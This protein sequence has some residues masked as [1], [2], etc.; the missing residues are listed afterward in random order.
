MI[1]SLR[2]RRVVALA[3]LAASVALTAPLAA[4]A[5]PSS[6]TPTTG[7][8][9]PKPAPRPAITTVVL[10]AINRPVRLGRSPV[11]LAGDRVRVRGILRHHVPREHVVLT[12]L[13]RG[14]AVKT[15]TLP[16]FGRSTGVFAMTLT[17]GRPGRY[18]VRVT[19]V[20][21][22]PN[23][24]VI[25][26][27]LGLL[28]V[29]GHSDS[30]ASVSALERGLGNLGYYVDFS[31]SYDLQTQLAVLAYRKVNGMDRTQSLDRGIIERVLRGGGAFHPRFP[32]AG[33]HVEANLAEQVVALINP[34]G[35]VFA[36]FP[37]SSGKPSTPTV[38]GSFNVDEKEPG[39]NSEEMF[40][41]NY[42]YS[43]YAIHG[44]PDVP[45]YP[46]SHGCLR[47]PNSDAPFAFGWIQYGTE[48]D[49]Y[50]NAQ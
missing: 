20:R 23:P 41:S 31:G 48:V 2:P 7:V 22:S 19:G 21:G 45:T 8:T 50:G 35:H 44:Y 26:H 43:G 25:G 29:D 1:A 13:F 36:V 12:L 37:T 10:S 34:G 30:S 9:A 38:L 16:S 14:R 28:V 6:P 49:V 15:T 5:A 40:D 33:R 39:Y 47:I 46:A 11:L 3:L 18:L 32:G 4:A 17:I 42:F 27:A 24:P